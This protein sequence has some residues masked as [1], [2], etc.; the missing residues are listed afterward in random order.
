MATG[1][2][3]G[4]LGS[5]I[6]SGSPPLSLAFGVDRPSLT[7]FEAWMLLFASNI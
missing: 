2:V 1:S 4:G 7:L 3:V 5:K 6:L